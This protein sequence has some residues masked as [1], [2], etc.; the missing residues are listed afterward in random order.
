M[1]DD[2][3][4]TR[5]QADVQCILYI[6]DLQICQALRGP[7]ARHAWAPSVSGVAATAAKVEAHAPQVHGNGT[8]APSVRRDGGLTSRRLVLCV[9]SQTHRQ[10]RLGASAVRRGRCPVVRARIVSDFR[11][12]SFAGGRGP[13]QTGRYACGGHW[14]CAVVAVLLPSICCNRSQSSVFVHI[15]Y[16]LRQRTFFAPTLVL[17]TLLVVALSPVQLHSSGFC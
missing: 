13:E 6:S 5:Y 7:H 3:A 15:S 12:R 17:L 16:H 4:C 2:Y 9:H 8:R 11:K 1:R 10:P 14:P